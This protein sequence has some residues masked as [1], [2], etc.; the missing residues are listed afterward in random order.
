MNCGDDGGGAESKQKFALAA[1][2]VTTATA[3]L[4]QQTNKISACTRTRANSTIN[5]RSEVTNNKKNF[6][7]A[8]NHKRAVAYKTM[9]IINTKIKGAR[10]FAQKQ[11]RRSSRAYE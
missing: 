5:M 9:R 3:R 6:G 7:R 11:K 4:Q 8:A 2:R 10:A 1:C